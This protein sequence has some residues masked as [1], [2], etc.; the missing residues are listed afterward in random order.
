[1]QLLINELHHLA[2][3]SVRL[4][5]IH[6]CQLVSIL[7]I[8]S[9]YCMWR[10]LLTSESDAFFVFIFFQQIPLFTVMP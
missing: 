6:S 9:A 3:F 8:V 7:Y 5:T 10:N 2:K 1:M 4:H